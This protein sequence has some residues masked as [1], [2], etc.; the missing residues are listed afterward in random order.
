MNNNLWSSTYNDDRKAISAIKKRI[1]TRFFSSP[2]ND[3]RKKVTT[4]ERIVS[5]MRKTSNFIHVNFHIF[6]ILAIVTLFLI[7]LIKLTGLC[8]VESGTLRN[9]INGGLI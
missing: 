6:L 1:T 5:H 7:T 8:A 3:L 9:F 4:H 2:K